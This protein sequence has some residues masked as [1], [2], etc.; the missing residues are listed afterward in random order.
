MTISNV[1]L[2]VMVRMAPKSTPAAPQAQYPHKGTQGAR[3]PGWPEVNCEKLARAME[4]HPMHLRAVLSG[5]IGTTLTYIERIGEAIG[6]P[7]ST[8]VERIIQARDA[9]VERLE[10]TRERWIARQVRKTEVKRGSNSK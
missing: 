7:A 9:D 2:E 1:V 3:L 6:M 10:R 5:R 4:C 8:V